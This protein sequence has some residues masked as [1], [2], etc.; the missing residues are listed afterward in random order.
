MTQLRRSRVL[1]LLLLAAACADEPTGSVREPEPK[2]GPRPVGIYE[3][4]LTGFG[5]PGASASVSAA[6]GQALNPT[7]SGVVF[8]S[9]SAGRVSHGVRTQGGQR[10]MFVTLRVRNGTSAALSNLTFIP[11]ISTGSIGSTPFTALTRPDGAP[12]D[13]TLAPKIVPTGSVTIADDGGLRVTGTDV[14]QVFEESEVAAI[15]LPSGFTGIFPYG[16]VTRNAF[17]PG[18]R[19]LPATTDPNEYSGIVTFAFRYPQTPTNMTEPA[20]FSFQ[21]LGV[22]DTETRLTESIEEAHDSVAVRMLRERATALGATTVTVLAGSTA[23]DPEVADYPGQRQVCSVRTAGTTGSPLT[24]ITEPAAYT[25][26]L[27]LRPGESVNA[28]GAYFRAGTPARPAMGV[29]FPLTATAMDLYGN[30]MTTAVDSVRLESVSGP[31]VTFGPRTALVSGQATIQATYGYV[32][33]GTS[34][35]RAVGR[36]NRGLQSLLLWG[37]TRTWTG[38]VS[39]AGVDGANW[40]LGAPPGAQDTAYLPA[41][42]PFYIVMNMSGPVGGLILDNGA[43][44]DMGPYDLTANSLVW[45]GTAGG[46]TST[47]GRLILTGT[48]PGATLKGNLPR[49]QVT[50]GAYSLAGPVASRARVEVTGGRLRT[51]GF[52][53]QTT[54]N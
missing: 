22:E 3:I 41:G 16:F 8:E 6:P 10:Y 12:V 1:P 37:V 28:C 25:E 26:I 54:A 9:L 30:V 49:M 50:G 51:Q 13:S 11:V 4:T 48:I 45:T 20:T 36:R 5:T 24:Y 39:T 38:N 19:T 2:P 47:T 27:V 34:V 52:R 18:S 42:R 53:L 15:T 29:P 17:T 46:I 32:S 43:T 7:A 23:L 33:Y 31:Y 44:I 40:D 35:L 14:L 21:V